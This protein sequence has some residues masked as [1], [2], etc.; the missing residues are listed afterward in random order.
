MISFGSNLTIPI[1]YLCL[2]YNVPSGISRQGMI[3]K[4]IFDRLTQHIEEIQR[5]ND[6]QSP[7]FIVC[8]DPNARIGK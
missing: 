6:N 7:R 4:D 8:G 1:Q 2:C 3:D 5:Q